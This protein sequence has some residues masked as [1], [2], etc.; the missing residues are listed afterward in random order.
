MRFLSTRRIAQISGSSSDPDNPKIHDPQGWP[1]LNDTSR[2][3]ALGFDECANTEHQGRL[4]FF[5]GD[6]LCRDFWKNPFNNSHLVAWTEDTAVLQHGGH[7][8]MGF[9][10]CLPHDIGEDAHHQAHWRY[11]VQ[12]SGLFFDGYADKHFQNLCPN[13][14]SHSPA[15]YNFV[16]PHDLAEDAHHQAQ[17]RYCVQ[18]G[19]L[20]FDGYPDKHFQNAC[21]KGGSHAPAGYHFVLPHDVAEDAHNQ[22]TWRYCIQC[23]GLFWDGNSNKGPCPGAKSGG[24]FRLRAVLQPDG[25]FWRFEAGAPLGVTL[26][27]EP[28]SDAFSYGGRVYVFVGAAEATW[29]GQTRP[30]DPAYGLYL[31]STDRPE[32]AAVPYRKEFLFNPRIGV[33]PADGGSHDVL[34]Y[35]FVLPHDI[36]GDRPRDANWFRCLKCATLFRG[37][38]G[39]VCAAGS[40]HEA[41]AGSD[42]RMALPYDGREDSLD[43]GKWRRCGKCEGMFWT[44]YT[45]ARGN[46]PADHAGHQA[47]DQIDYVLPHDQPEDANHQANWRRCQ[48]C[49]GL[50]CDGLWMKGACPAGGTHDALANRDVGTFLQD[51]L[52]LEYNTGESANRQANW[53]F[54]TKCYGLFFDG[55]PNFK[56]VCP[57][58][59]KGHAHDANQPFPPLGWAT[60]YIH[61]PADFNFALPHDIAADA[62]HEAG[63]RYCTRCAVLFRGQQLPGGSFD[64]G[65][66]PAGGDHTPAGYLF[67]LPHRLWQDSRN[68]R[69]WR[70]CTKCFGMVSTKASG[71]FWTVASAVVRNSDFPGLPSSQSGDGLVILGYGWSDFYLAWM[72]L[73]GPR[74]RVQDT[75]YCT[76]TGPEQTIGWDPNVDH[77]SG[78]FGVANLADPN[79]ISMAWLEG[80]RRWILLYGRPEKD[81][82][83]GYVVARIGAT[84][85]N[86]SEEIPIISPERA[87]ELYGMVNPGSWPYGPYILKRFTEWN[88]AAGELG[89]YYLISLSIGYQVHLMYTRLNLDPWHLRP[90]EL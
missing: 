12:C 61:P 10:F 70:F 11:C 29:S 33:C 37:G 75:L 59:S 3:G 17:W 85:W 50:F 14:G 51:E 47:A 48:K 16:L 36:A 56:G 83:K 60:A 18:C 81:G 86:W 77:A 21:P 8:A 41:N 2:W 40:G 87:G 30:G 31:V 72:P 9:N 43:Q 32:Q 5:A 79:H 23:G 7:A 38:S 88:A 15:G 42:L 66:C 27:D 90:G 82:R 28:A 63:W 69:D 53:R 64:N 46:C 73:G 24:G 55:Y 25:S 54:C 13:G 26:S 62:W 35:Q 57:V 20:F 22:A 1:L 68:D 71:K 19:G 74:L 6:V 80:P 67:V 4:Y 45:P 89:I 34:G 84:P 44:G 39:G 65:R 78:L 58:D 76:I 52:I 49:Y